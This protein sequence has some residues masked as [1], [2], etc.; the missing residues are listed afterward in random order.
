MNS[1]D[2]TS[3]NATNK[4]PK[5]KV[6]FTGSRKHLGGFHELRFAGDASEEESSSSFGT[7]SDE[8]DSSILT[9]L[10]VKKSGHNLFPGKENSTNETNFSVKSKNKGEVFCDWFGQLL[11]RVFSF[12][13]L[14]GGR[15]CFYRDDVNP[16]DPRTSKAAWKA[17][18]E[19]ED[20]VNFETI[21]MKNKYAN[22]LERRKRVK[23]YIGK[24][25]FEEVDV[26]PYPPWDQ[27]II[28]RH[29]ATFQM[30]D[31]SGDGVVDF[32]EFCAILNDFGDKAT[33][34]IRMK[35]F[36]K[37]KTDEFGAI[38]F[39]DFLMIMYELTEKEIT[40]PDDQ[41]LVDT[42]RKINKNMAIR[43]KL[44]VLGQLQGGLF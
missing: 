28:N 6:N 25:H 26:T 42:F 35:Y 5:S 18:K 41:P 17:R 33:P 15:I 29:R 24:Y 11:V 39:D 23:L 12:P 43:C 19:V 8:S 7:S 36:S 21:E 27:N 37:A 31:V 22:V 20:L 2:A 3:Q 34:E 38:D 4:L 44:D 1:K 14:T 32:E 13:F 16:G 9:K 40:C 30:F 10:S